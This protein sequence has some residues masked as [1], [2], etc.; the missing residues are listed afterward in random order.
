MLADTLR[1]KGRAGKVIDGTRRAQ[2]REA[3]GRV[4]CRLNPGWMRR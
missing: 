2:D 3:A 4:C 1:R